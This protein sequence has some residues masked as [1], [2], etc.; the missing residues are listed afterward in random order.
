MWQI[1]WALVILWLQTKGE[2]WCYEQKLQTQAEELV[3][4]KAKVI[5][6]KTIKFCVERT[7]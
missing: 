6:F 2:K 4:E 3:L 7:T 5:H 1:L